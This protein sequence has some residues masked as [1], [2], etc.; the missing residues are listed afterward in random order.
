MYG[1]AEFWFWSVHS[2][3]HRLCSLLISLS[4]IKVITITGMI[5]LGIVLDLGG[6]PNHD[7][8]GFRYWK[9]PGPFVNFDG[10]GGVKGHFLGW[11]RVVTQAAFSYV[12]AEVVAVCLTIP[13][14]SHLSWC[15][16]G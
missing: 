3:P 10:I 1:E 15:L 14:M 16:N 13:S 12:G 11:S 7:R 9:N 2:G 8:I 4:S 5:I 6:G